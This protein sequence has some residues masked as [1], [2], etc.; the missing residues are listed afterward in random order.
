MEKIVFC[1]AIAL[2]GLIVIL[3]I[4]IYN[5]FKYNIIKLNKADVN[6]K[7]ALNKKYQILV[8]YIDLLSENG[9][10]NKDE[11]KDFLELNLKSINNIKLMIKIDECYHEIKKFLDDNEKLLKNEAIV[12]INKEIRE[13]DIVI[14]SCKKYYNSNL[15]NYNKAIKCFPSKII[16]MIYKYKE[17]E[18]YPESKNED[19]KILEN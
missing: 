5:K 19:L 16:A 12:L 2:I 14:N 4:N 11:F 18:F 10:M 8:R 15:V 1:F 6:I 17:K 7:D 3:L 9:K 13:Q